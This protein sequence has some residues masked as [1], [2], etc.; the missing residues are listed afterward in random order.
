M[1]KFSTIFTK[2]GSYAELNWI[3]LFIMQHKTFIILDVFKNVSIYHMFSKVLYTV[4]M[5]KIN[6]RSETTKGQV[7][8]P[9]SSELTMD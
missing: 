5:E 2:Y 8:Q 6:L 1:L 4:Q 3:W 7:V 9:E